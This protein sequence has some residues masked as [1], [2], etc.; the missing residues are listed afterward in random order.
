M[1]R[2]IYTFFAVFLMLTSCDDGDLHPTEAGG[3]DGLQVSL[4]ATFSGLK[5]WPAAYQLTLAAYGTDTENPLMSIQVPEPKSESETVSISL[6]GIPDETKTISISMLTKGRKLI[7]NYY[8]YSMSDATGT[9]NITL[10]VKEIDVASF[11]RIQH[12]VFNNYCAACHGAGDRAAAGL[13]L[14]E[15]KSHAALVNTIAFLSATNKKLVDPGMPSQ[16]FL[17]DILT[18][19]IV[20]Y[21][22]ID[23]LP[24]AELV[25]LIKTWIT[26]GAK[27]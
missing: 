1:K 26:N 9:G 11:D 3:A 15:G 12:Q 21:N 10:P 27:E 13:Y 2:I 6:N 22:H 23:V 4:Q 18:Q 17:T 14:T 8:T 25:T 24:E 20:N 5:A 19:D 7:Y 16:S